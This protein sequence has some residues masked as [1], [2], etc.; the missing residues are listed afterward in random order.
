MHVFGVSA[1]RR[2]RPTHLGDFR[3]G[4][5]SVPIV[6]LRPLGDQVVVVAHVDEAGEQVVGVAGRPAERSLSAE[7]QEMLHVHALQAQEGDE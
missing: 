7:P 4:A 5:P 2:P 1:D 6:Q 3:L